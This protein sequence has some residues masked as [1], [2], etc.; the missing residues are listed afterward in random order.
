MI[1]YF[2]I[3]LHGLVWTY[4]QIIKRERYLED[5]LIEISDY[6]DIEQ[7]KKFIFLDIGAHAGTWSIGVKKMFKNVEIHCFEAYSYYSNVLHL[8]FFFLNLFNFKVHNFA[9]SDEDNKILNLNF[10]NNSTGKFLTGMSFI[11]KDILSDYSSERV[12]SISIDGFFKNK[13]LNIGFIKIDIE[14]GELMAL[15]GAK[16]IISSDRPI[17]FFEYFYQYTKKYNYDSKKLNSFFQEQKYNLF[18]VKNH[19][20][21]EKI[22]KIQELDKAQDFFA[23][24]KEKELK[25][26]KFK[27]NK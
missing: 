15:N 4:R 13:Q 8:K 5:L 10:K 1:K 23:I 11:S 24:P 18:L 25:F 14:G 7:K 17:I 20:Y 12:K 19:I 22:F 3:L 26:E 2:K 9:V 27:S 6:L 16:S 21:L